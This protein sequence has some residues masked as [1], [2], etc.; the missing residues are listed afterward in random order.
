VD[1]GRL[2][3]RRV[4]DGG[5]GAR[6]RRCSGRAVP[7]L[8]RGHVRDLPRQRRRHPQPRRGRGRRQQRQDSPAA[9]AGRADAGEGRLRRGLPRPRHGDLALQGEAEEQEVRDRARLTSTH[10]PP[11]SSSLV[12][13]YGTVRAF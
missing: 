7:V 13:T 5:E 12:A 11:S 10:A 8:V 3:R 9:A 4:P 1:R 6:E 2:R